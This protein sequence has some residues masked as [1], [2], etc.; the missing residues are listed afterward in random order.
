MTVA[1]FNSRDSSVEQ[2]QLYSVEIVK[3][4]VCVLLDVCGKIYLYEHTQ[5]VTR[6]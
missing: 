6:A 4:H 1:Y 5:N 2:R 3:G